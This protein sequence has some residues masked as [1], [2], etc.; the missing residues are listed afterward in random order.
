MHP[1][2]WLISQPNK[3]KCKNLQN[4]SD[5]AVKRRVLTQATKQNSVVV[6]P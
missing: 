5:H 2:S 1:L 3:Q 4:L 6:S